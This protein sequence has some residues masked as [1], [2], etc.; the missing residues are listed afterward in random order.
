MVADQ[1]PDDC[2]CF[3]GTLVP[4]RSAV[5]F[6]W[7]TTRLVREGNAWH[8]HPDTSTYSCGLFDG[9]FSVK[10]ELGKLSKCLLL[11]SMYPASRGMIDRR[12]FLRGAGLAL[13]IPF[14]ES[15]S[16]TA[17]GVVEPIRKKRI[18]AVGNHLGF[19]PGA[20][21]PKG[22]GT[23]YISSPTLKNI[24]EQRKK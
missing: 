8:F 12:S 20:F 19:Y 2:P 16:T 24:E 14:F 10:K 4:A 13:A 1:W 15:T 6:S 11:L 5:I 21:F 17:Y 7:Y 22:E 3:G 23:D 9:S 18:L